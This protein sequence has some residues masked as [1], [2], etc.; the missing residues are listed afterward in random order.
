LTASP[1]ASRLFWT[2]PLQ[3][4]AKLFSITTSYFARLPILGTAHLADEHL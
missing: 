1:S 3:T 2:E 4:A